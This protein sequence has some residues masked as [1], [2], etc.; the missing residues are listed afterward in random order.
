M[1]SRGNA[2]KDRLA[3][4]EI[5]IGSIAQMASPEAVEM[6]AAAGF[7]WVWID[8]EHGSFGLETAVQMLRAAEAKGVTPVVRVP[9][10]NPSFIMRV[11]DAGALGVMV[12]GVSRKEDAEAVVAAARYSPLGKRGACPWVRAAEHHARNWSEFVQWSNE[13][14]MLWLL[15]EGKEGVENLD[16]ILE[17]P[18]YDAIVMGPFDLSQSLGHPGEIDHPDVVERVESM[19]RKARAKGIDV[20]SVILSD[21]TEDM[22]PEAKRWIALGS[23]IV[24]AGADKVFLATGFNATA[25]GIRSLSKGVSPR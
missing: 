20:V 5:A 24:A 14:V 25:K 9:D 3:A 22:L 8:L 4:G 23:R 6:I 15:V 7:D 13:N 12:P 2:V 21:T 10:H 16:E 17:V 1:S 19:F 11:L 18:G